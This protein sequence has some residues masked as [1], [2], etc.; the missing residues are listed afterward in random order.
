M[1][2]VDQTKS[3]ESVLL[4]PEDKTLNDA[5]SFPYQ[6]VLKMSNKGVRGM[7]IEYKLP[8]FFNNF[9]KFLGIFLLKQFSFVD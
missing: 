9:K 8:E 6:K 2:P 1:Q 3:S 7:N 4:N 5:K